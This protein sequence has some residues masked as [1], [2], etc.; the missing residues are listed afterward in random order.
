MSWTFTVDNAALATLT[1]GERIQQVYTVQ[2]DDGHGGVA[3]QDVTINLVGV[4]DQPTLTVQVLTPNGMFAPGEDPIEEMGAGAVQPGG[5]STHF[6][7][8]NATAHREFVFD[9]YGFTFDPSFARSD[10]WSHHGHS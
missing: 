1:S 9:G 10:W 4:T 8:T 7:I 3:T 6:T 2:I 5:T